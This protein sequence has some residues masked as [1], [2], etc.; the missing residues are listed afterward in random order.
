M[1]Y[2]VLLRRL[3]HRSLRQHLLPTLVSEIYDCR[4]SG[5]VLENRNDGDYVEASVICCEISRGSE[6]QCQSWYQS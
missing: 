1:I 5:N 2:V 4:E 6:A 3:I